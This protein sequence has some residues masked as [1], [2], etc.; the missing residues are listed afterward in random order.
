MLTS[1][2]DARVVSDARIVLDA[3]VLRHAGR[4]KLSQ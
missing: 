1:F 2:G 3:L 4:G